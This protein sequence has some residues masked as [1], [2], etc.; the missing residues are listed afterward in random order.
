MVGSGQSVVLPTMCVKPDVE[1]ETLKRDSS[2]IGNPCSLES[3]GIPPPLLSAHE[4]W[5]E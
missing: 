1:N 5:D 3:Q 4:S 2:K